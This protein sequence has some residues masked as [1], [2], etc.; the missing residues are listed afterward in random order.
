M[1]AVSLPWSCK[2]CQRWQL[3]LLPSGSSKDQAGP[4]PPTHQ[5]EDQTKTLPDFGAAS[6]LGLFAAELGNDITW[7]LIHNSTSITTSTFHVK[8]VNNLCRSATVESARV[9][10]TCRKVQ[11]TVDLPEV[12]LPFTVGFRILRDEVWLGLVVV[13]SKGVFE[14]IVF[15]KQS[16]G[17]RSGWTSPEWSSSSSLRT[18]T[19]SVVLEG[20]AVGK[21]AVRFRWSL[22]AFMLARRAMLWCRAPSMVAPSRNLHGQFSGQFL[23]LLRHET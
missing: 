17:G 19:D 12:K 11:E 15:R 20:S 16:T 21:L 8:D 6:W 10:K 18:A 1:S 4:C 13:F 3:C 14:C 23:W 5:G 22:N 7:V 2:L 9:C